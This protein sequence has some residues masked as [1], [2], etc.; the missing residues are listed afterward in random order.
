MP[1]WIIENQ[2][3][4]NAIR[5]F[6]S[7][8]LWSISVFPPPNSGLITPK[9]HQPN[10]ILTKP[11]LFL[12][13]HSPGQGS[14]D[15]DDGIL[16]I[17]RP[18]TTHQKTRLKNVVT[19]VVSDDITN[20]IITNLQVSEWAYRVLLTD[21]YL[22]VCS[23]PGAQVRFSPEIFLGSRENTLSV[24]YAISDLNVVRGIK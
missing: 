17:F 12:S 11:S 7:G 16:L 22:F 3:E 21:C 1:C 8:P 13:N 15:N 14:G 19:K 5:V 2:H 23:N 18:D 6:Q 9:F 20:K 24:R 4:D 10:D